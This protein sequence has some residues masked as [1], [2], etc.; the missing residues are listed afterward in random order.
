[1]ASSKKRANSALDPQSNFAAIFV[2][3]ETNAAVF[4]REHQ[5]LEQADLNW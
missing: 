3:A 1:M 2:I 4:N 5:N